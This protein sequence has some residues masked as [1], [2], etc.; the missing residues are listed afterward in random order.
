VRCG[1]L[2]GIP[3]MKV[4]NSE[5]KVV[6]LAPEN[7]IRWKISPHQASKTDGSGDPSRLGAGPPRRTLRLHKNTSYLIDLHSLQGSSQARERRID[8]LIRFDHTL[9]D[10][11]AIE[12]LGLRS[13][14]KRKLNDDMIISFYQPQFRRRGRRI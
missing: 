12:S 13:K 9:S 2:G 8:D 11:S 10:R 6:L 7:F 5:R 3:G 1:G 4:V 14:F